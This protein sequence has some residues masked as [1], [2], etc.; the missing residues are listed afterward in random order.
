VKRLLIA[1]WNIPKGIW[2]NHRGE[3]RWTA[4]IA[5]LCKHIGMD[6]DIAGDTPMDP[7]YFKDQGGINYT[8]RIDTLR[9]DYDYYFYPVPMMNEASFKTYY[10]PRVKKFI[11]GSFF[12]SETL[13]DQ[14]PPNSI[15][16]TPYHS[17][18]PRIKTIPYIWGDIEDSK[19]DNQT[20]M[21]TSRSMIGRPGG[22]SSPGDICLTELYQLKALLKAAEQ[23]YRVI[24]TSY[25]DDYIF[26]PSGKGVVENERVLAVQDIIRKLKNID[27]VEWYGHIS[28]DK[29]SDIMRGTSIIFPANAG[30]S[31]PAALLWG[32]APVLFTAW[33][34]PYFFDTMVIPDA[35]I[36]GKDYY[37][38]PE[39]VISDKVFRLLTD[40]AYY[41]QYLQALRKHTL[42]Y[43]TEMAV[44]AVN[45]VFETLG[46]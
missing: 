46:N 26:P 4:N 17:L 32:I 8:N 16:V 36:L 14:M 20:L 45:Q 10:L 27:K 34:Y 11:H 1:P 43:S 33:F 19:F 5:L 30:G 7:V 22:P 25:F 38:I 18:S 41:D 35:D 2:D 12:P 9:M 13:A 44:K 15:L 37:G 21:W 31:M 40:K 6:V 39:D 29:F 28:Q 42:L 23:G 3:G 24:I